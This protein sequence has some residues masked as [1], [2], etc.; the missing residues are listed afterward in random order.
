MKKVKNGRD[1]INNVQNLPQSFF[2]LYYIRLRDMK[3][4]DNGSDVNKNNK[5][6]PQPYFYLYY[7]SLR[8]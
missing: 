3:K 2:Y 1:M 7:I 4:I 5:S 6:P 8:G